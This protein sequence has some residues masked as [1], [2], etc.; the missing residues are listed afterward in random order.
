ML[1]F[2]FHWRWPVAVLAVVAGAAVAQTAAP[3]AT[4]PRAAADPS[5]TQAEVPAA[6]YR[7]AFAG[8]RRHAEAAPTAWKDANDTV[9]RIGGWR[10]YAREAAAPAASAPA[11]RSA[12]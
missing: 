2:L 10:T 11:G 1:R 8:Y 6:L 12:P 3:S 5:H 7:S 4:R 9:T